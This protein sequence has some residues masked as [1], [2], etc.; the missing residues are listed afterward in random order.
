MEEEREGGFRHAEEVG[1]PGVVVGG[2]GG[3]EEAAEPAV[4]RRRREGFR[5]RW[6][7]N[8][9]DERVEGGGGG[10]EVGFEC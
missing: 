2:V 6:E 8:E 5:W 9:R 7:G 1:P 3:G 10:A 4:L